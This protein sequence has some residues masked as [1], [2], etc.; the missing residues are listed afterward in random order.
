[1]VLYLKIVCIQEQSCDFWKMLIDMYYCRFYVYNNKKN[2]IF[3]KVINVNE[4]G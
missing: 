2:Y 3:K 4:F 1:M